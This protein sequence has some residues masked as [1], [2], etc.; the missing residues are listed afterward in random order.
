MDMR[1]KKEEIHDHIFRAKLG[2]T[3]IDVGFWY[4]MSFPRVP[5]GAFDYATF[6]TIDEVFAGGTARNMLTSRKDVGVF[7]AKIIKDPRTLNKRVAAYGEVL[8]QNDIHALIEQ[9][10]GESLA[11]LPQVSAADLYA[12]LEAARVA[13]EGYPDTIAHNLKYVWAQY[14]ITK[15]VREDN[16]PE[17]AA[18]LGYISSRDLYPDYK[19]ET[20]GE[21]IDGLLT[22]GARRPYP[23]LTVDLNYENL[24][25]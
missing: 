19:Y 5:S 23:A 16:T 6:V 22:K 14:C 4:E 7:T 9:K 20:F 21:F 12:R 25:Q 3:I 1:D 18:Y 10:T 15:H 8:S 24:D 11:H 2:F 17:N 13:K